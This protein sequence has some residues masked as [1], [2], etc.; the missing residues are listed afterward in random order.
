MEKNNRKNGLAI[1]LSSPSGGGKSSITRA[2]I[3]KDKKLVKFVSVT[4]RKPRLGDIEAVQYFF[5]SRD[6]FIKMVNNDELLEYSEIYNNL[7]GIPR[8]FIEMQFNQGNNIIF[9]ID[10]QGAYKLKNTLQNLVI[11]IFIL[12][13]SIEELRKRLEARNQDFP[14]EV[15]RRMNLAPSEMEQAKNYDYIVTNDDFL[16]TVDEIYKLIKTEREIR[17]LT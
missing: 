3:A 17:G 14:E 7:Y 4:T 10:S 6:E 16:T 8:A 1:I 12:P 5:K 13:P 11:S 2:L 9:D 15:E